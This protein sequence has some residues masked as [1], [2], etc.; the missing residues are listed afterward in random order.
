MAWS[1][2]ACPWTYAALQDVLSH[3]AFRV[4]LLI[5]MS[6]YFDDLVI[7]HRS[8]N[9]LLFLVAV[10]DDVDVVTLPSAGERHEE[11][12]RAGCHG[13]GGAHQEDDAIP[14]HEG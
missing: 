4:F 7:L 10:V 2:M 1:Y 6:P 8:M 9:P 5:S 11:G 14:D 12:P 3:A 13:K